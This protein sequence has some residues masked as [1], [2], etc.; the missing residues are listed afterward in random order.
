MKR[1]KRDRGVM[2]AMGDRGATGWVFFN[3]RN[4]RATSIAFTISN[5]ASVSGME[6][7][8]RMSTAKVLMSAKSGNAR[9]LIAV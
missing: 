1:H 5:D 6:K 4:T 7:T 2:G 8:V 9:Y 3:G